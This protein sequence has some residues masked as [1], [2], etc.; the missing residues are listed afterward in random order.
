VGTDAIPAAS[1]TGAL[2]TRAREMRAPARSRR[3]LGGLVRGLRPATACATCTPSALGKQRHFSCL[4][5]PIDTPEPVFTGIFPGHQ[6]C[7][8][9]GDAMGCQHPAFSSG[10]QRIVWLQQQLSLGTRPGIVWHKGSFSPPFPFPGF[11][12]AASPS[13]RGRSCGREPA[14][15]CRILGPAVPWGWGHSPCPSPGHLPRH[16]PGGQK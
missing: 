14:R 1:P 15:P 9:L 7:S 10:L 4:S 2:A 5:F 6:G 16:F 12:S 8:V 3:E 11:P 13:L